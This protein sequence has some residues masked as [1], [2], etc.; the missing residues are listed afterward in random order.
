MQHTEDIPSV[1]APMITAAARKKLK[2]HRRT[3]GGGG[4]GHGSASG[5]SLMHTSSGSIIF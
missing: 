1:R 2:K 4:G 5:R 3:K